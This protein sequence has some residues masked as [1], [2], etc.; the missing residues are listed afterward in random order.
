MAQMTVLAVDVDGRPFRLELWLLYL[1]GYLQRRVRDGASLLEHTTGSLPA[2]MTPTTPAA[3]A[4]ED[5]AHFRQVTSAKTLYDTVIRHYSSL[6]PATRPLWQSSPLLGEV[7]QLV[8]EA[9]VGTC[10]SARTGGAAGGG[11]G[12]GGGQLPQQCQQEKVPGGVEVASLCACEPACTC[13]DPVEALHTFMLDSGATHCFF[14]DCTTVTPLTTPVQVTLVDPSGGL[15]VARGS[16]VLPCP[17]APSGSLTSFHLPSFAKNLVSNIVLQDM[18]VTVTT[19]GGELVA[20]SYH[21]ILSPGLWP[22]QV[23]APASAV[24]C[25]NVPSLRRRA[26]ASCSSLVLISSD[27]CSSADPP[28]GRD[29][30][31]S[32]TLPASP[33]Q[34]GIAERRIGLVM[35]VARTS[36]IHGAAPHFLW[37]FAVRCAAQQLNPWPRVS[38]LETSPTL[39]WTGEVGDVSAF[40]VWGSLALV[41]DPPTGKLSPRT[42]R[43]VFL[44]FPTDAPPWQFYHPGS[45][46]VLSS[47]GVTF[48]ESGPAPSSVALVD[49][50][51]LVAP[52][53]VSSNTSGLAEGGDPAA[54]DTTAA[55]RLIRVETP[56]GFPPRP[57]SP[58]LQPVAV[59]SGADR[60]GNTWGADSEGAGSGGAGSGGAESPTSGRVVG[61]PA[62]DSG[63]GHQMQPSWQETLSPQQLREWAVRWGRPAGG[64]WGAGAGGAGAGGAGARGAGAGGASAGGAGVVLEVQALVHVGRRLSRCSSSATG[65]AGA[66]GARAGGAGDAGVGSTGAGGA[67]AGG[68]RDAGTGGTGA[69]DAGGAGAGGALGIGAEGARGAGTVGTAQWRLFFLPQQ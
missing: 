15:V 12:S 61:T 18:F 43:C 55:R 38:H 66:G 33:Q 3:E 58:P 34:N 16:T 60:G 23:P 68:A 2:P 10:A 8:E 57:S 48:D 49:P 24:A 7:Q 44:G 31:Q 26:T 46:H 28:Y 36:M 4:G 53:K 45:R 56:P 67:G 65:G 20:I 5:R 69:G 59:D 64:A 25:T 6:S 27:H 21:A 22:A 32:F 17:A 39:R 13:A 29:L 62:G 14:R 42:L 9:C 51:A 11:G 50:P 40:R 52:L 37:L 35:E 47:H 63:S 54:D 19:H 30:T 41:P 1:H